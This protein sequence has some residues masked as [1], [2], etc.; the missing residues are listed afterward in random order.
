M[1]KHLTHSHTDGKTEGLRFEPR[2]SDLRGHTVHCYRKFTTEP[3]QVK[4]CRERRNEWQ[5]E[6]ASEYKYLFV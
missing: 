1:V 2:A 3:I 4:T 6:N 5:K